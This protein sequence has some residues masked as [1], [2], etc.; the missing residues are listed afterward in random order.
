MAGA[1]KTL[2]AVMLVKEIAE[3][4]KDEGTK[5]LIFFLAPKVELVKQVVHFAYTL[6]PS[7][8]IIIAIST[9]SA[10]LAT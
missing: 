9:D 2:I 6:L 4:L 10:L 8:P 7:S 1:G 5:K 3:R